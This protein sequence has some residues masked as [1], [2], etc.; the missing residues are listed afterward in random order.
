[1]LPNCRECVAHTLSHTRNALLSEGEA[2][3]GTIIAKTSQV[4]KRAD[5]IGI[6]GKN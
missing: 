4:R 2:V 3:I 5:L 6:E 1:M